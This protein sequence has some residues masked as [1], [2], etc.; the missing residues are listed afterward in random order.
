MKQGE[1][2]LLITAGGVL[3]V[4]LVSVSGWFIFKDVPMD[5]SLAATA[6]SQAANVSTSKASQ[7]LGDQ[8][9]KNID[10]KVIIDRGSGDVAY[11]PVKIEAGKSSLTA[12]EA[13]AF[14]NEIALDIKEFE[15]MGQYINGIGGKTGDSKHYWSFEINGKYSEVG[16]GAYFPKTSDSLEFVWTEI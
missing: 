2:N 4:V 9:Q 16:V 3:V 12:L 6:G 7:V 11:Y 14:E 8:A 10:L 1:K 5:P 15:G 13:V